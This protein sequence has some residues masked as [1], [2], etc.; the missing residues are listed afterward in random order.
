MKKQAH[1]LREGSISGGISAIGSQLGPL[2]M[3]APMLL[4]KIVGSTM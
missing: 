1:A 2:L 3:L 4:P